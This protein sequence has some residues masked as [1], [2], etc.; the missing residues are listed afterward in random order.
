MR[1]RSALLLGIGVGTLTMALLIGHA[2]TP[3]PLLPAPPTTPSWRRISTHRW[4]TTDGVLTLRFAPD[5]IGSPTLHTVVDAGSGA[6]E[7]WYLPWVHDHPDPGAKPL[8]ESYI[9]SLADAFVHFG[10]QVDVVGMEGELWMWD[11]RHEEVAPHADK[12]IGSAWA[13]DVRVV[14]EEHE[15]IYLLSPSEREMTK[16]VERAERELLF[17]TTTPVIGIEDPDLMTQETVAENPTRDRDR[18]DTAVAVL[19]TDLRTRGGHR[20]LL[21]FGMAHY[22]EIEDAVRR[23]GNITLRIACIPAL[24]ETTQR[25]P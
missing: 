23:R 25:A 19:L 8:P 6:T 17:R 3:R 24:C 16:L 9:D 14:H 13:D 12:V 5:E 15:L 4:L 22:A 21:V 11:I 2:D 10:A 20:A 7:L 1:M 18:S